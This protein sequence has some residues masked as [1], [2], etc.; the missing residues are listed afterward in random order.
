VRSLP[1]RLEE[2]R[3][4]LQ[5]QCAVAFALLVAFC[6]GGITIGARAQD[7]PPGEERG[8]E[9][10]RVGERA[11]SEE[12]DHWKGWLL[13]PRRERP[14]NRAAHERDELAARDPPAP[15]AARQ[16]RRP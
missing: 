16:P 15:R 10:N 7:A 5:F 14:G 11:D 9:I 1:G 13:R 12:S 4:V 8:Y 3:S 6:A 2:A